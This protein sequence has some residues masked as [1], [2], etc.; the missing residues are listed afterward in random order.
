MSVC[1]TCRARSFV[2]LLVFLFLI[3]LSRVVFVFPPQPSP[4]ISAEAMRLSKL[5]TSKGK[6]RAGPAQ[7]ISFRNDT[8]ISRHHEK[9]KERKTAWLARQELRDQNLVGRSVGRPGGIC[10]CL[11]DPPPLARSSLGPPSSCV[12]THSNHGAP[13]RGLEP[14]P[15]LAIAV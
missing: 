8:L 7:P 13:D 11:L 1:A 10:C 14:G 5:R 3:I 6:V 2:Y 12:F 4:S 9:K 15:R